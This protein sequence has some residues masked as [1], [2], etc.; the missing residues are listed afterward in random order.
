MKT[1]ILVLLIAGGFIPGLLFAQFTQQGAKL[2]GTGAI[3]NSAQ[4][5]SVAI[6]ADGN[7]AIVGGWQDNGGTGAVWI[8]TRSAGVWIQQG[9]KLIGTGAVGNA[10][11]GVSVSISSDGNTSIEGGFYDNNNIGAVWIF[12]R[13]NGVWTQQGSKLVG[14]GATGSS[15]QG[16][17]LS[18]SS[19]GNTAITGGMGDDGGIGAA[20]VFTRNGGVW[21]QQGSKIIGTNTVGSSA[22]GESVALSS[23]GNTAVLGGYLDNNE[24]GAVWIFTRSAGVWTQQGNKLFGTGAIGNSEQGVSV[25]ISSDGNTAVFGGS[26]DNS[27]TGAVWVF[28][29]SSGLWSQQGPKLVG[30]GA[31]G[32]IVYHGRSVAVSSDGNTV[33]EGGFF[34]NDQAG[35]V[36]VFTRN[37]GVWSQMGSKLIGTGAIGNAEQGFSVAISSDGTL[38]DG[39]YGDNGGVG[40]FWVFYDPIIGV[41]SISHN[42]PSGYSLLQN[43]PNPFNP[44][45]KIRFSVAPTLGL[46]LSGGDAE[47]VILKIYDILGREI[48]TL[49]NAQMKPGTYEVIWDA[50]S[51]SS[52]AYFYRLAAGKY[53]ETKKMVVVK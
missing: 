20:W 33:V 8:F 22:Q 31:I 49:V 10:F 52:G 35:A 51:Y 11:Q 23:D 47:G 25:A 46:P 34:D 29:R 7:T 43:Y 38:I 14:T 27:N 16:S 36:W 19:D 3:G 6:S 2:V 37:N 26:Q 24:A 9:P 21:T 18:I 1:K 28:T 41:Q 17:S 42:V 4:G 44:T 45:T 13:N 40:A 48:A 5:V 53:V 50:T 30:T 32:N 15:Y 39:G 12:T